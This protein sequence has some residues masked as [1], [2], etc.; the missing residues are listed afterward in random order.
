[1]S[2]PDEVLIELLSQ[3]TN[4]ITTSFV[5]SQ[6]IREHVEFV[7]RCLSNRAPVR[8]LM[9][10][11]LAKID[12]PHVD[13]RQPYTEIGGDTS[14]S[15]RY[16][17]EH[18]ITHF[19]NQNRLPCNSTTAFLT[20]ALRNMDRVLTTDLILIG[21]PRDVYQYTLICNRSGGV[22]GRGNAPPGVSLVGPLWRQSRHNGPTRRLCGGLRPPRPRW[23]T[24]RLNGYP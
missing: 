2:R 10:C 20:P 5:A 4:D 7:C 9:A 16:Y 14:F 24:Y 18:Y 15:G 22:V 11:L 17:D 19:I 6:D 12:R 1:M 8:L 3:A 13:P 23:R 21:R